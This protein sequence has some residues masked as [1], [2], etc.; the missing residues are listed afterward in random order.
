M[1][2]SAGLE[3]TQLVCRR[4]A[5]AV[6]VS[7]VA[8][9]GLLVQAAPAPSAHPIGLRSMDGTSIAADLYEPRLQPAPAV[10]SRASPAP[11]SSISATR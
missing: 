6:G 7:L 4:C 8:A 11:L 5:K 3:H 2:V 1:M 10:V 9:V